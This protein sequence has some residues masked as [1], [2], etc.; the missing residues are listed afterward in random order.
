MKKKQDK[1]RRAAL[2]FQKNNQ[3]AAPVEDRVHLR[4]I[5]GIKP[6]VYLTVIYSIILLVILF[7]ILIFPGLVNPGS[8]IILKTEPSGAAVRVDGVYKGSSPDKIF[9]S[10]GSRTLELA[11]P[12]FTPARIQREIPGRLFAS[13]IFPKKIALE[14]E[15][16]SPDPDSVF[17]DA[18]RDY[19]AWTFAGEPIASWQIPLSLSEGAY[20]IAANGDRAF[21]DELL[22]ASA[23]F[24]VTKA[25]LRDLI[26]AKTLSDNYGLSPSP[27]S[28]CRSG[29]DILEFLSQTPGAAEWL[30]NLLPSDAASVIRESSGQDRPPAD[31]ETSRI[32]SNAAE[33]RAPAQM[34]NLGTLIYT[35]ISGGWPERGEPV[36]RGQRIPGFMI[37]ATEVTREA[38]DIF[39]NENPQWNPEN[40]RALIEQE[41]ASEN[42]LIDDK[43]AEI[44]N[45]SICAVSW[46]AA[47]AYC[48]WL[49]R[50]LPPSMSDYEVRL[51]SEAEWE[52]AFSYSYTGQTPQP[53]A[54]LTG[55]MWEWCADPYT[56][57]DFIPAAKTAINTLGSPE[58]SLRGWINRND[59]AGYQ[60]RASL[61]PDYC[62]SFISFRPVIVLK[63]KS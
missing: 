36:S 43:P 25:A 28:L 61:P 44:Q 63:N 4:S 2:N 35:G 15:L 42:Y 8:L 52:F 50:R 5:L 21:I 62:S 51:P 3:G 56:P 12:G 55:N 1:K 37:C 19:A 9:V 16:T 18:A 54:A 17:L 34:L 58:R 32:N 39:L 26:R 11:L 45:S 24:A 14:A 60:T 46:H 41:Q 57:L 48:Q 27:L 23:R 53:R 49:S 22:A 10:K 38:F 33:N 7:F 13:L 31:T 6:G 40:K 59:P 29:V 20:R 30:G 47:Q